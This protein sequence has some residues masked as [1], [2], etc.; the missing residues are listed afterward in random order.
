MLLIRMMYSGVISV[1]AV[2]V[3]KRLGMTCAASHEEQM[4][5]DEPDSGINSDR[6]SK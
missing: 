6:C 2:R 4:V 5:S 3:G 1:S